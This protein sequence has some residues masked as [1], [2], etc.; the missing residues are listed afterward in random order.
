MMPKYIVFPTLLLLGLLAAAPALRAQCVAS[1]VVTPVTCF[2]GSDGNILLSVSNASPV[3]IWSWSRNGSPQLPFTDPNPTVNI[4]SAT[5]GTYVFTVT[6]AL[7]CTAITTALVTQPTK[8][9]LV[10]TASPLSCF[11][12]SDASISV[13]ASGGNP[14]YTYLWSDGATTQSR[15]NLPAGT[16]CVT[17]SDASGCTASTCA[18]IGQPPALALSYVA[19][20]LSC[21]STNSGAIDLNVSGGTPGYTYLWSNGMIT[22]DISSLSAGTYCVTVTDSKGCTRTTCATLTQPS[23]MSLSTSVADI[24]CFGGGNGSIDLTVTGGIFSYTYLWSSGQ[25]TQDLP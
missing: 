23:P 2:G 3:Y 11:G 6:D 14:A 17:V 10:I 20:P 22:Q 13:A 19:T 8:L 21:N 9:S 7:G 12:S 1:A 24:S 16:Y 15:G 4:G 5:A 18:S 25:K